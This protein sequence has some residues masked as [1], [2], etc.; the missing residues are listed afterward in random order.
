MKQDIDPSKPLHNNKQ[1]RFCQFIVSGLSQRESLKKAGYTVKESQ[2]DSEASRLSSS[3]KVLARVQ[4]LQEKAAS[5]KV[6]T[7]RRA[8]EILTEMIETDLSDFLTVDVDGVQHFKFDKE[9]MR[10]KALKKVKTKTVRDEH[11]NVVF[12]TM[13]QEMEL[14]S[15]TAAL[16]RLAK[17]MGWDEAKKI[18]FEEE[19]DAE[20]KKAHI[21][22]VQTLT[23][24]I[25]TGNMET[26]LAYTIQ[27]NNALQSG[28]PCNETQPGQVGS[29]EAPRTA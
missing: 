26:I 17:M 9:T 15:K 29:G 21:E 22:M 2:V 27:Q 24:A 10:R 20:S 18:R 12:D 6:M 11:G 13:F 23:K 28:V 5:S 3:V 4:Y 25:E 19:H 8:M 16:E 14:E 1:E 7:R